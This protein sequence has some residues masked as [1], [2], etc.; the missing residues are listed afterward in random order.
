MFTFA[1]EKTKDMKKQLLLFS[2]VLLILAS[3]V[4]MF[5]QSKPKAGDLISGLVITDHGGLAMVTVTERDATDRIVAHAVTDFEGKFSFKLVDSKDRIVINHVDYETVD[6]PV[7]KTYYRIK[8]K[9]K[10]T[11]YPDSTAFPIPLREAAG[12]VDTIDMSEFEHLGITTID[13]NVV[14]V[15]AQQEPQVGDTISGIVTDSVSPLLAVY[16]TELDS[17]DRVVAYA[18]TDL[19]GEFSFRLVNPKDRI[20]FSFYRKERIILPIDKSYFEIRMEDDK[21]LPPVSWEDFTPLDSRELQD[22]KEIAG[23][24]HLDISFNTTDPGFTQTI[25]IS[26]GPEVQHEYVD[27][28]LSVKWAT[29]NIGAEEPEDYGDYFAW[30]E[31]EPYYSSLF[32]LVWKEGHEEGYCVGNSYIDYD[33]ILKPPYKKYR[34]DGKTVLAPEDDAAHVNRGGEWRM[35]TRE[36]FEE[37]LD[38][39][40]CTWTWTSV[41]GIQ[42]YKVESRIKGFKGNYIFLPGADSFNKTRWDNS[43]MGL[44]WSSTLYGSRAWSLEFVSNDIGMYVHGRPHGFTIRPVHP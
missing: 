2:A 39:K 18:Y 31:T 22:I 32:P 41:C 19:K 23:W 28:G 37:L 12:A 25:Q 3:V 20:Q 8:M 17:A 7:D 34:T 33:S 14:S 5:A 44:Y 11:H 4:S 13:D 24:N 40:N 16:I 38:K 6:V 10:V 36:E 35:P 15:F 30:G 26:R 21:D 27:L 9:M 43:H 29:C 42:G 1:A